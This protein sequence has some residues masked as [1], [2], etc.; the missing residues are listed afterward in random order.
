MNLIVSHAL[1]VA[2]QPPFF[3]LYATGAGRARPERLSPGEKVR[4]RLGQ[5]EKG[6]VPSSMGVRGGACPPF[7]EAGAAEERR[8]PEVAPRSGTLVRPRRN[9]GGAK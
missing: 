8:E 2:S 5:R 6:G 4:E 7:S 1:G 9:A 3:F